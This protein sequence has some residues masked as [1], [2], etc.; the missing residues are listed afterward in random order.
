RLG[1]DT[2]LERERSLRNDEYRR[3]VGARLGREI[4]V[5]NP[6]TAWGEH[7]SELA[8]IAHGI[9][10]VDLAI[11]LATS[12]VGPKQGVTNLRLTPPKLTDYVSSSA[13]SVRLIDWLAANRHQTINLDHSWSFKPIKSSKEFELHANAATEV[14]AALAFPAVDLAMATSFVCAIALPDRS[15]AP[16]RVRV[17]L[18]PVDRSQVF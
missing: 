12:L 16:V 9:G 7:L 18:I 2:G 11:D 14:R 6:Y 4:S 15:V 5:V 3:D 17:D 10:Q 1:I 13:R 8:M